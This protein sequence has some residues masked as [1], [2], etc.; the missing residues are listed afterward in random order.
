MTLAVI[1]LIKGKLKLVGKVGDPA[2]AETLGDGG[3]PDP[4]GVPPVRDPHGNAVT[5]SLVGTPA[6]GAAGGPMPGEDRGC[7]AIFF[8]FRPQAPQL[9][10]CT[11][12]RP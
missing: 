6:P 5:L 9:G 12:L 11:S 2:D 4:Y 7:R 1:E 8:G 10:S 3:W